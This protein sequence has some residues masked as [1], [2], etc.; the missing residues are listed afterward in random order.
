MKD[1]F[2]RRHFLRFVKN[3]AG[4]TLI[5]VLVVTAITAFLAG[6]L[7]SY[8]RS[9]DSQVV[10]AAETARVAGVLY[11]ARSFALQK[12]IMKGNAA[13]CGFGVR[14]TKPNRLV[15]F[16]DLP[17]QNDDCAT[18]N[19]RYDGAGELIE[20]VTLN[21][22]VALESFVSDAGS[23]APDVF[24]QSPYLVTNPPGI[25]VTL[26]LVGTEKTSAV[27]VGAGGEVTTRQ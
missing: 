4:F 13:A 5:E 7:L 20:E 16:E 12:N 10:L 23:E 11:R 18:K 9:T 1:G 8:N 25:T 24:F 26:R 22:R 17:A 19:M 14:F 15:L 6:L 21:D 27:A 3:S 2:A